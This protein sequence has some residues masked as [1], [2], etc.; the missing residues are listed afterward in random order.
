MSFFFSIKILSDQILSEIDERRQFIE[1]MGG[2]ILE[3]F[4]LF[5]PTPKFLFFYIILWLTD[6]LKSDEIIRIKGEI[7]KR[8]VE[9]NRLSWGYKYF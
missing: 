5:F 6:G 9:L 8:L 1:N 3:I 2:C 7:A 4:M